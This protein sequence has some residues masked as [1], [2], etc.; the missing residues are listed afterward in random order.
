MNK[1]SHYTR[2][3]FTDYDYIEEISYLEREIFYT[4]NDFIKRACIL[5]LLQIEIDY[6]TFT[7]VK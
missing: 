2:E 1:L 6:N 7:E 4:R 5:R 3:Y